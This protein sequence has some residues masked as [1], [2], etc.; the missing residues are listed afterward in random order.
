MTEITLE[1][2]QYCPNECPYCSTNASPDGQPLNKN[3]ILKFLEREDCKGKIERINISGGEPLSHPDFYE[4]LRVCYCYTKNVWVY[5][6]ALTQII[7]NADIINEIKIEAN[8]CIAHGKQVYIPKHVNKVHL[9]KLVQQG[10]GK[11]FEYQNISASGNFFHERNCKDCNHITLQADG[12]ITTS[13]CKK[14]YETQGF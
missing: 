10:R 6:N 2:T 12:Q 13:P 7:Y 3:I 4:I 9:L 1:I 11:K 8:V 14:T 5:T